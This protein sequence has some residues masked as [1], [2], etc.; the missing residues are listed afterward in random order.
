M[1]KINAEEL[2]LTI[3]K[4]GK[5]IS[6]K[7]NTVYTQAILLTEYNSNVLNEEAILCNKE[8]EGEIH[9]EFFEKDGVKLVELEFMMKGVDN[10]KKCCTYPAAILKDDENNFVLLYK[11]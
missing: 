1:E 10:A 5:Y 6:E 4:G 3:R 2:V 8:I 11:S 9:R 7:S